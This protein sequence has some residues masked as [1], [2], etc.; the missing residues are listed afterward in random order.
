MSP[1]VMLLQDLDDACVS[2]DGPVHQQQ[3]LAVEVN[4]LLT[5]VASLSGPGQLT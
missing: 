1:L 4:E 3:D 2:E 5:N